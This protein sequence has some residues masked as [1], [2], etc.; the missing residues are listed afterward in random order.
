MADLRLFQPQGRHCKDLPANGMQTGLPLRSFL[1]SYRVAPFTGY[2]IG[3]LAVVAVVPSDPQPIPLRLGVVAEPWPLLLG[4]LAAGLPLLLGSPGWE[5]EA[6][7]PVRPFQ[8]RLLLAVTSTSI[9]FA[10]AAVSVALIDQRLDVALRNYGICSTLA[11]A[12]VLVVSPSWSWVA[13]MTFTAANWLYGVDDKNSPKAW[14]LLMYGDNKW[15]AVVTASMAVA[16][17]LAWVWRGS[18]PET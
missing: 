13:P 6:T 18:R 14:A 4:L 3:L 9:V 17:L 1:R 7:L 12:S 10:T 2:C 8:T 15:L 11:F 5:L 16:S